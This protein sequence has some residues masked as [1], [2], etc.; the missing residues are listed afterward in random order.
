MSIKDGLF[1]IALDSP[2]CFNIIFLLL[3]IAY[4]KSATKAVGGTNGN[5]AIFVCRMASEIVA[6]RAC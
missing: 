2:S 4:T 3:P 1:N 5:F 6:M